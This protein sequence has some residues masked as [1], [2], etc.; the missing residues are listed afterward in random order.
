MGQPDDPMMLTCGISGA[1]NSVILNTDFELQIYPNPFNPST[2][3]TFNL[4]AEYTEQ[5]EL[6]IY[7]LKGQKVRTFSNHQII[8]SQN[9]QIVWDG[10]DDNYQPVSSGIYFCK[11]KA[12][13]EILTKK[14]MLL[15]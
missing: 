6:A 2:A 13:K 9:H 12:G 8:Q 15:K 7:N 14:L 1:D 5:I 11:L 10:T 3:I 4:N